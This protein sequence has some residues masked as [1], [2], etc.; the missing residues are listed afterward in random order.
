MVSRGKKIVTGFTFRMVN[1]IA[2]IIVAFFMMPFI[3]HTL[4]DRMYGLWILM[5]A[6][7]GY[8][9]YLDLGILWAVGRYVARAMG[10]KD[11][12]EVTNFYRLC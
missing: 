11:M 7:M 5:S 12:K 1:T 8:M 9:G 3:L 2:G 6:F 10:R 4:G